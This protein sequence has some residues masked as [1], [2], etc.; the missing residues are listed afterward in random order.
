M[1]VGRRKYVRRDA[2]GTTVR[3]WD[4]VKLKGGNVDERGRETSV[5]S[6]VR[7]VDQKFYRQSGTRHRA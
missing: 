7:A 1:V 5:G 2:A 4:V 6:F 3:R